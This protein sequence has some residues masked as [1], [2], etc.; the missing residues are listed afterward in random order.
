MKKYRNTFFLYL[1]TPRTT[2]W[3]TQ[4]NTSIPLLIGKFPAVW[5]CKSAMKL[6]S[7]QHYWLNVAFLLGHRSRR[8]QWPIV[9]MRCPASVVC[10]LDNLHFQL[11][12]QNPFWWILI[13]LG[14]DEV[15]KVPYKCCCF[16]TRSAQGRI[17]GGAKIGHGGSGSLRNFFIRPEGYRNKPNA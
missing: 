9:I 4:N 12:L 15:H 10:P 8:L 13:K 1:D 5:R 6:Y 11:L 2:L 7:H 16:W 17:Q 3:I 14:M